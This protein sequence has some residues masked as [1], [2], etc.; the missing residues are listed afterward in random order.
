M[1]NWTDVAAINFGRMLAIGSLMLLFVLPAQAAGPVTETILA[2]STVIDLVGT[3]TG[4]ANALA[5]RDQINTQNDSTKYVQFGITG[6][7]NYQG[8]RSYFLPTSVNPSQ[9]TTIT[10]IANIFAPSSSN[11]E[12]RWS[13]YNWTTSSYE[14][15]GNQNNCGGPNGNGGKIAACAAD[16]HSFAAWKWIQYNVLG[17]PLANYVNPSTHEIRVQLA[18]ANASSYINMDYESVSVYSNSGIP[19]TPWVP[20]LNTR[21]Q[22]QIQANS[23]VF[24]STNGINVDVCQPT[25]QGGSC[26]KPDVFDIDLYVDGNITGS[27]DG[28]TVA[29]YYAFATDAVSAIHAA[30]RK[31]IGYI[32]V[33]DAENFRADFQQMVDFDVA[34]GHCFIGNAFSNTFP[35]EWYVNINNDKGQADFMRKMVQ[36]RMDKVAAAGFDSVEPDVDFASS[37]NS[38]FTITGATQIAYNVSLANIAHANGLSINLKSDVDQALDSQLI[39]A[40]DYVIDEQCW[41]YKQCNNYSGF[42]SAGKSIFNAEYK[43]APS[44][45]CPKAN[46]LNLNAIKKNKNFSLFDLPW[47]PCR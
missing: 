30:G 23:G 19:G 40:F 26:V 7:Q 24:T 6:G 17:R 27:Y 20:F 31:V 21:W 29:A 3:H 33:G 44:T 1:K 18:S 34:C 35:N 4:S 13:L 5:V 2:P 10:L 41:Q 37:N 36:A 28:N 46:N 11:D 42:Q 22:W 39:A 15:L 12:F 14:K 8:Y 9:I 43:V 25:Y 32:T 38:G 45:F 47:T 16:K